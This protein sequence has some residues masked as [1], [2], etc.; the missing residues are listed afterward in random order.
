MIITNSQN[1]R[2]RFSL[3]YCCSIYQSIHTRVLPPYLNKIPIDPKNNSP[4][5]VV[6]YDTFTR[7]INHHIFN[8]KNSLEQR[9]KQR[10]RFDFNPHVG[11]FSKLSLN[12][13]EARD[14]ITEE[15]NE[16]ILQP[17]ATENVTT[18]ELL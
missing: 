4:I 3:H 11:N 5:S 12:I 13:I 14:R 2:L 1:S 18:I 6:L 10:I 9:I 8:Q 7:A 17:L 16:M 15:T